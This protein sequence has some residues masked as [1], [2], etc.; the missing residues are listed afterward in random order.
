MVLTIL[1]W[2]LLILCF[3]G[4]FAPDTAY[5]WAPRGRVVIILILLA[6]LGL[7]VFDSPLAR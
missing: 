2:I 4:A 5:P 7:K 1:F 6:I 3:L